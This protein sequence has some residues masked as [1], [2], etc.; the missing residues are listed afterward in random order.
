MDFRSSHARAPELLA[1]DLGDTN[2]PR[3]WSL[4]QI[5]PIDRAR[6][7]GHQL[8]EERLRIMIVDE[9]HRCPRSEAINGLKNEWMTLTGRYF[10]DVQSHYFGG[11]LIGHESLPSCAIRRTFT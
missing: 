8:V 10:P 4:F 1:G 7:L 6:S 5:L 9:S 3:L 2:L 11:L